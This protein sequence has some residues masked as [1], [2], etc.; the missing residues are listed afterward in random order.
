LDIKEEKYSALKKVHEGF[1]EIRK[2]KL[3]RTCACFYADMMGAILDAVK[4]FRKSQNGNVLSD[5]E[6]DFDSWLKEAS[7][8][9]LHK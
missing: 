8:L 4:A 5:V 1:A 2:E 3:C 9:E 6:N 7:G